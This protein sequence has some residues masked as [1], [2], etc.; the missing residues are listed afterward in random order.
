MIWI[1][2][3]LL[4]MALLAGCEPKTAQRG[5]VEEPEMVKNI[6]PGETTR[7][8]VE[9]KFGSPSS[10]T[11]FGQEIW[12]YVHTQKEAWAFLKPKITEQHV[13][14][15]GFDE[16]GIVTNVEEYTGEDAVQVAVVEDI[17][18]TEGHSMGFLEQALGNVGRFTGG[19][20]DPSQPRGPSPR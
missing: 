6:T 1:L 4:C 9:L 8:Q 2:Q 7:R 5:Q 15:I 18:P 13:V 16:S 20:R 10:Q 11:D 17:T 3:A 14:A 19:D 12:Y